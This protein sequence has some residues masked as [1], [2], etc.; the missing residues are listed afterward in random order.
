MSSEQQDLL[1]SIQENL[2]CISDLPPEVVFVIADRIEAAISSSTR[3]RLK[4]LSSQLAGLFNK[5]LRAAPSEAVAEIRRSTP[6]DSSEYAAYM[7]GQISFAQLLTAQSFERRANDDFITIIHDPR[8]NNYITALYHQDH[9]GVDLARINSEVVETVSRKLK[10]L[11]ELG[12]TDFRREGN[13]I[14]NFLTPTAR[15]LIKNIGIAKEGEEQSSPEP[16]L[17]LD[18]IFKDL[19][20]EFQN[21][22]SF[23]THNRSPELAEAA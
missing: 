10:R 7:L 8:Y 12:I 20:Q 11:R 23:A 1:E 17:N 9:T 6:S 21:R 14:T 3:S 18:Y 22:P 15:S 2:N 19:G 13:R 16:K 5:L 4:D